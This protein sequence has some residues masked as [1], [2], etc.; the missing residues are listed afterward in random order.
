[1][2]KLQKLRTGG[3][4]VNTSSSSFSHVRE[5]SHGRLLL[6][7]N[8]G[9][10]EGVQGLCW[11]SG[12]AGS[13]AGGTRPA[14]SGVDQLDTQSRGRAATGGGAVPSARRGRG[15]EAAAGLSAWCSKAVGVRCLDRG[16]CRRPASAPKHGGQAQIDR[17]AAA[18]RAWVML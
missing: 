1:M 14:K 10:C 7:L 2:S 4:S 9:S 13:T 12:G 6:R 8:K 18:A 17:P 16:C 15:S 5:R 11:P 3:K